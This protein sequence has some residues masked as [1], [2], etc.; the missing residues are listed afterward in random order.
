M[1]IA[2]DGTVFQEAG[3]GIPKATRCLYENATRLT[4]S[5]DV[6]VIHRRL[7]T[8][9]FSPRI[10]SVQI[11]AA[12]PKYLWR[13]LVLPRYLA[14]V[15]PELVHFVHGPWIRRVGVPRLTSGSKVILTLHDVL[16]L[17]IPNYFASERAELAYRKR[18]QND[19]DRSD[20]VLTISKFSKKQILRNFK[21]DARLVVIYYAPTVQKSSGY[22][23]APSKSYHDYFLYVGGYHKRKG[24]E[25][26]LKI[27]IELHEREKLQSKLLLVGNARYYYPPELKKLLNQGQRKNAVAELGYVPDSVL[28][29]LY[30]NAKAL[31]YPSKFEG[32]GLPPLEAMALGCPVIT[33]KCT[34]IPEICG[35]AV[36][37]IDPENEEAFR[38]SLIDVEKNLE[39]RDKLA[40]KGLEQAKKFTWDNASKTFLDETFRLMADAS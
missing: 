27:F 4:R 29:N 16:P 30:A 40:R 19:L 37:Y 11:G 1:K 24:I 12:V 23:T 39:L 33:T 26:M 8:C 28:A 14:R 2:V 21:V 32:F 9:A 20:L 6:T 38:S 10:K 31:I 18:V 3:A 35:D 34:A 17:T 15:K 25:S 13:A 5:L 36:Y 7:L 22:V